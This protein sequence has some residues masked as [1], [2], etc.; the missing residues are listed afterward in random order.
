MSRIRNNRGSDVMNS[1]LDE[2][3][4]SHS[5]CL[6]ERNHLY[7]P[8][9]Q[10][11]SIAD[12]EDIELPG[13]NISAYRTSM[14]EQKEIKTARDAHDAHGNVMRNRE[15][16]VQ[17][18]TQK[19][20]NKVATVIEN[21]ITV[22]QSALRQ[23]KKSTITQTSKTDKNARLETYKPDGTFLSDEE[24]VPPTIIQDKSVISENCN[25]KSTSRVREAE[26]DHKI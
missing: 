8:S 22:E 3:G 25:A 24:N 12:L 23:L 17:N 1:N 15:L 9:Y 5:Y 13:R 21:N 19:D 6:P 4:F 18:Q 14:K 10:Q 16:I 7:E 20:I 11:E 2:S 26:R